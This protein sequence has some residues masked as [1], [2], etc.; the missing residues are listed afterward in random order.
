SAFHVRRM[1]QGAGQTDLWTRAEGR[2]WGG[3]RGKQGDRKHARRRGEVTVSTIKKENASTIAIRCCG[4]GGVLVA[5]GMTT[6]Y[7]LALVVTGLLQLVE[8][9]LNLVVL[10]CA[11]TTQSASAGF[12]SI[13]GFGS[14]YHYIM[15]YA[16]SGFLGKEV[17]E[18]GELDVQY[19]YK[20]SATVYCAVGI[21]VI[22]FA[23][24]LAFLIV[25]C[26]MGSNKNANVLLGEC[27]VNVLSGLAYLIG[28]ALYLHYI[29]KTNA[30]DM[31][32]RRESLY[33]RHGY[34]SVKCDILGTEVAVSIFAV[35]LIV[36]YIAGVVFG[37]LAYRELRAAQPQSTKPPAASTVWKRSAASE[38]VPMESDLF[39]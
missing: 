3:Q 14:T 11:A 6:N 1:S 13:G 7:F 25:G 26:V 30:T 8:I 16:N 12:Q 19:N 34:T 39:V 27:V 28:V 15:G 37:V 18:I 31:C 21:S 9:I 2:G 29:K 22:L 33:N 32:K 20:K 38:V 17:Q 24:A 23:F 5:A 4:A 35:M 10:I 36:V